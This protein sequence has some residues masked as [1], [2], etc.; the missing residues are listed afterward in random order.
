MSLVAVEGQSLY[1]VHVGLSELALLSPEFYVCDHV[2]NLA[3][4]LHDADY[5]HQRQVQTYLS[6]S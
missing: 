2:Y 5:Y 4:L 6:N 3:L 1:E